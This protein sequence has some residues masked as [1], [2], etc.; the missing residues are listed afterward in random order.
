MVSKKIRP[1]EEIIENWKE[2]GL[3]EKDTSEENA[4]NMFLC[5]EIQAYC[6]KKEKPSEAE[7]QEL[8][9]I[10]NKLVSIDDKYRGFLGM[11]IASLEYG[12]ICDCD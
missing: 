1:A 2:I 4:L 12:E 7:L 5:S 3:I 10:Y 6:K 9:R 8:K 11:D